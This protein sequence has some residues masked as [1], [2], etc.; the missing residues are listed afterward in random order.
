[1]NE[2]EHE[3]RKMPCCGHLTN[4]MKNFSDHER[5]P[6]EGDLNI[7]VNCAT[8]GV[9]GKNF[10]TRIADADDLRKLDIEQ[11]MALRVVQNMIK[12]NIRNCRQ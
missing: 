9:I 1:M 11:I 6:K 7:C 8:V 2:I 5:V 3:M 4:I 10:E 12:R